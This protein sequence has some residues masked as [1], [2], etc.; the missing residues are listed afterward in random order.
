M[1]LVYL[2]LSALLLAACAPKANDPLTP[3]S[4]DSIIP[5][6]EDLDP[7]LTPVT[8]SSAITHVQPMTGLVLWT[9]HSKLKTYKDVISLEYSYCLPCKV[10]KG[11]KNGAVQYDWSYFEDLLDDIASRNHQAIVRFRYEYPGSKEVNGTRGATAVP[12]YIKDLEGYS[13]TKYT[14]DDGQT[15]YADWSNAELQ[16]FTRQF[17]TDFAA[18]Y[19]NDARIAFVEVGFGHWGEYHIYG[20]PL[21]LGVNFPSKEYQ[22]AFLKHVDSVLQLPWAISID[23]ADNYYTPIVASADLLA[24]SFGLFDDSFMHQ[25][26]EGDYNEECWNK[27]GNNNR[28]QRGVCGGEISY[29]KSSDQKNFLNPNG[30]YGHTWEEQARKYHITFMISNDAPSSSGYGTT[31]RFKEAALASG[32]RFA[33]T[34]CA[35]S[36]SLTAIR[37]TNKGVAPIYY[38][39]YLAI[40]DTRHAQSLRHLMPGETWRLIFPFRCKKGSDVHIVCD[41]LLPNQSIEFDA[42]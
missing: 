14:N 35:T 7:G 26:H 10:V 12:Q 18:R 27:I 2:L 17:Y 4:T 3:A 22:A 19:N 20:T 41:H 33:I 25:N 5:E 15:Y 9:T 28:W 42:D 36:D 16:W 38:D 8:L 31:A 29:Y 23:A 24:L 21:D 32:Y 34:S 1:R 30:M 13:E 6:P 40:G 39:A 11:K 37:I